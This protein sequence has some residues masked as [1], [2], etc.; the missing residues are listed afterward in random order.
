MSPP[1]KTYDLAISPIAS[2]G[3][4]MVAEAQSLIFTCAAQITA[5]LSHV[6]QRSF[7][8]RKHFR[9]LMWIRIN[10]HEYNV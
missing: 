5:F 7:R 2:A 6:Q 4:P 9:K 3:I 10:T 1:T 8:H